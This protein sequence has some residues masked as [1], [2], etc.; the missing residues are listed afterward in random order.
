MSLFGANMRS[1]IRHPKSGRFSRSPGAVPRMMK[2]DWRTFSSSDELETPPFR[3]T[4]TG[5]RRP[6]P[7][8][9]RSFAICQPAAALR[10]EAPL[11]ELAALAARDP[12][13]LFDLLDRER[14]VPAVR[15]A[16]L[17]R[18]TGHDHVEHI[19]PRN[20]GF[21]VHR[22]ESFRSDPLKLSV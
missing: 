22:R 9:S 1:W 20:E 18:S 10:G 3:F 6:L 12:S 13:R 16:D 2:I 21:L 5:N 14:A 15:A 17:V 8:K 11:D 7:R 19:L 4:E